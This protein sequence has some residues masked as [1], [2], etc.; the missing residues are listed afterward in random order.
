MGNFVLLV[1]LL[2]QG[3][4][5]LDNG[6]GRTPQMGWNSWNRIRCGINQTIVQQTADAFISTGLTRYVHAYATS[7]RSIK[8]RI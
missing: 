8:Q 6:L 3:V 4:L 7:Y 1:V 5:S 2:A